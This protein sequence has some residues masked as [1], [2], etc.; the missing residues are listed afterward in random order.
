MKKN[1]KHLGIVVVKFKNPNYSY[2][3][4]VGADVTEDEAKKYFVGK[5]LDVGNGTKEN[6]Q[7]AIGI[8]FSKASHSYTDT[9]GTSIPKKN[10]SY[11]NGGDLPV[12]DHDF[13]CNCEKPKPAIDDI[14]VK[15][16]KK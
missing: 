14:G 5:M 16:C 8:E 3:T 15:Y 13:Y 12:E 2:V 10:R 11:A 7:K 9:Y 6:L 1:Q 4:T